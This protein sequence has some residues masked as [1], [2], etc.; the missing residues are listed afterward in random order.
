MAAMTPNQDLRTNLISI[1]HSQG[2]APIGG[3]NVYAPDR[4]GPR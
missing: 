1:V 2:L 4:V 3:R